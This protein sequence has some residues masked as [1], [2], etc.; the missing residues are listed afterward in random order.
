[1][2]ARITGDGH[3]ARRA[4]IRRENGLATL[5]AIVREAFDA[6]LGRHA[7]RAAA[8]ILE[9]ELARQAASRP[10][11]AAPNDRRLLRVFSAASDEQSEDAYAVEAHPHMLSHFDSLPRDAKAGPD[12][13]AVFLASAFCA[14]ACQPSAE[15]LRLGDPNATRCA[16]EDDVGFCAR[17]GVE[18]GAVTGT[19]NCGEER[20]VADCGECLVVK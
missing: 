6:I 14:A 1:M 20:S 4:R 3:R 8:A 12:M 17:L 2:A 11:A 16:A 15:N 19:D 5:R 10:T 18:C 13:R 9:R 7:G